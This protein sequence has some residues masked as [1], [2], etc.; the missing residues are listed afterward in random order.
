M[1]PGSRLSLSTRLTLV[2]VVLVVVAQGVSLVGFTRL[3]GAEGTSWRL[4]VPVRI[5][6]AADALDRI[7]QNQRDDI[8]VAMNGDAT[9]FYLTRNTPE[10]Y[11]ERHGVLPV[12]FAGYGA[13]LEGRDVQILVREG[14]RGPLRGRETGRYAFS[15]AL[16]DGQRLIVA[17]SLQQRRRGVA[18]AGLLLNLAAALVAAI[19]VWRTV[20]QAT[21]RLEMIASA[22]NRFAVDLDAPPMDETGPIEARQVAGAFNH[23]RGEIRRLMAERMRMLA[24]VA[25]DLKTL[26]TRL[27]LRVA[28][29]ED[30][31]QRARGDRD[32]ALAAALIEDVLMVARGEETP[33]VL[34][35]VDIGA[36]L[37]DIA[38]ERISLGQAVQL[39]HI[40]GGTVPADSASIRR[41]IENL[42]ENAVIYAGEAEVYFARDDDDWLLTIVDHGP[43]LSAD[44]APRAFEPFARGEASRSRDTGGSGLGL[45]IAWS[46]ARRMGASLRL[47][48]TP[49]GG[50]TAC[51]ASRSPPDEL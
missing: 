36:I 49:G 42:I 37:K 45:S 33:V 26:L 43:G 20:R 18:M 15:V 48:P 14:R 44:F 22:S 39:G 17:P 27:R 3:R 35:P 51:V 47:D 34:K 21:R 40:D 7:P 29:I 32:I 25:H 6:A 23:M 28:L 50:V 38:R 13:A 5:A 19:L 41:I 4:P 31:D 11:R 30:N 8:L 9:R 10:G 46:L 2:L 12:L 1:T 16:K 24:A